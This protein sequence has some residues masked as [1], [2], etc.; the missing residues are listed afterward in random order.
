MA[1]N[2]ISLIYDKTD[3]RP[4]YYFC[5]DVNPNDKRRWQSIED[6]LTC[7]HV[8]LYDQWREKYGDAENITYY[9][10]CKKHHPFPVTSQNALKEWHLPTICTA[11]GSMSPMMQIAVMMGYEEIY[12][13]GVDLFTAKHDHFHEEYPAY[14]KWDERNKIEMYIH[15]VAKKSSPV[16]IYN[17]TIG[18][19]L[20]VYPRVDLLR[21]L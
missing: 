13:V 5:M 20:E 11:H 3:W 9:P 18:G 16:P 1:L 21:I 14:C 8:F 12:L 15:A 2:A 17:A 19:Q 4:T 6:N 10:R 7:K